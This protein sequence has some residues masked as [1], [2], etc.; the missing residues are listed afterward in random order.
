M[1]HHVGEEIQ[2]RLPE[3]YEELKKYHKY[4]ES[5]RGVMPQSR[6][7]KLRSMMHEDKLRILRKCKKSDF[8]TAI[9]PYNAMFHWLTENQE[10]LAGPEHKSS[11][12]LPKMVE[13]IMARR[14]KKL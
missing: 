7:K 1:L 2:K 9:E 13:E 4:N 3:Y 12:T 11:G 14:K 6:F 5:Y 8:T 10:L